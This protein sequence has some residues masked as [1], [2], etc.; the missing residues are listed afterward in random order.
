MQRSTD[1]EQFTDAA[2]LEGAGSSL[3]AIHYSF[4]DEDPLPVPV[5]YYRLMQVDVN[6]ANTISHIVAV[7][8][9]AEPLKL[10][11]VKGDR[12]ARTV[13]IDLID[14]REGSLD[15]R[16]T[17]ALGRTL[18]SGT[19]TTTH[20]LNRWVVAVGDLCSGICT[21]TIADGERAVA[22]KLVY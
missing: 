16:L 8:F 11:R 15:Y 12:E 6:G 5:S 19:Q 22:G 7:T 4:I 21:L 14:D 1:G 10:L 9:K 2:W 13:T 20:G 3:S 17:D 18:L